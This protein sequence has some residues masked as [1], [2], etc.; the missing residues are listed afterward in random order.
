MTEVNSNTSSLTKQRQKQWEKL[1]V[2]LCKTRGISCVRL[3]VL[4]LAAV[5]V[6]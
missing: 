4:P 1:I 2:I 6:L 5:I 3:E